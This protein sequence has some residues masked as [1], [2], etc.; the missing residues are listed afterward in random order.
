MGCTRVR[1]IHE[2]GRQRPHR[3]N[4]RTD[5]RPRSATP[6]RTTTCILVPPRP[7]KPNRPCIKNRGI[8]QWL[9]LFARAEAPPKALKRR[10]VSMRSAPACSGGGGNGYRETQIGSRGT[11]QDA[12]TGMATRSSSIRATAVL[13]DDRQWTPQRRCG[14]KGWGIAGGRNQMVSGVR[15]SAPIASFTIGNPAGGVA[16]WAQESAP[17]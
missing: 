4:Q 16:A 14:S 5:R 17:R 1:I 7:A 3:W 11:R 6:A 12:I 2:V 15:R 9:S 10:R 8:R 13:A